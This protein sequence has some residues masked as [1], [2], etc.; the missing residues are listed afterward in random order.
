MIELLGDCFTAILR[1]CMMKHIIYYN[2]DNQRTRD[3]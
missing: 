3:P 1:T 2:I